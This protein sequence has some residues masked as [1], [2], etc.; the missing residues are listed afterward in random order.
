MPYLSGS[1][2]QAVVDTGNSAAVVEQRYLIRQTDQELGG[3]AA[4]PFSRAQRLEF[5]A[6]LRRIS[7]DQQ[8]ETTVYD[9]YS[10]QL[11][12]DQTENLAPSQALNLMQTSAALVYDNAFYG[13]TGPVAGQRYRLQVTPLMGTINVQNVLADYRRYFMPAQFYTIAF[14]AMHYGRYGRDSENPLLSPLFLGYPD[15][16]RGYDAGSFSANE[17]PPTNDN[18]CPAFDRL[19]GSRLFVGNVELRFPLFR[20]AGLSRRMYGWGGLPLELALFADTGVAWNKGETPRV[21]GASANDFRRPVSSAGAAIRVNVLGFAVAQF[22]LVHPFNRPQKG[23]V[24]QF[25]FVPGF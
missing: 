3:I 21:F 25:S 23:W 6:G 16:V 12:S 2:G 10:G 5:S 8:L 13:A 11:L 19:I 9:Y 22:D 18:T 4:Y 7:L 14:R 24:F 1:I 17:C 20:P 15:L